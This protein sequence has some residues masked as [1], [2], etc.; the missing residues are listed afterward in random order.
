MHDHAP[1]VEF[2]VQLLPEFEPLTWS[3]IVEP[4]V[5]VPVNV[6][7]VSFVTLS[8]VLEPVS[9]AV[10]RSGVVDVDSVYVMVT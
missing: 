5:A 8:V 4:P 9:L 1:V 7:V 2:A 10:S 6:G 3:W